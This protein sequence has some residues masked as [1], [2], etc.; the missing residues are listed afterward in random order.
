[1]N[2]NQ[3]NILIV[4]DD[5]HVLKTISAIIEDFGMV[6]IQAEN[7][8]EAIERLKTEAVDVILTDIVMPEIDGLEFIDIVKDSYP[9]IPIAVIS[10]YGIISNTVEALS[11][12]A[13]NFVTK[14]FTIQEIKTI[15]DKGL[16]LRNLSLNTDMLNERIINV[17][18]MEIPGDP[19]LF[20]AISYYLIKECQW[21]GIENDIML[22]NLTICLDELL[23][24]AYIHGHSE[25]ISKMITL[26]TRF[27]HETLSISIKDQGPG[28]DHREFLEEIRS[29]QPVTL[30]KKGLF[31]IQN[32]VEELFFNESGN[33]VTIR[34]RL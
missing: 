30:K 29:L 6:P 34:F 4:D 1:M 11:R 13:F 18:T 8:P 25:D 15:V 19:E 5:I 2:E 9:S 21:R 23:M 10:A 33:E 7:V 24:N 20:T 31:I 32:I 28:F 14:P 22:T 17:T 16:R 12:G 3:T 26:E 27:S